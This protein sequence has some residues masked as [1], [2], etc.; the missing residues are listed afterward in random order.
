MNIN[1]L[2]LVLQ[3]GLD[4]KPTRE[5]YIFFIVSEVV[6]TGIVFFGVFKIFNN[7]LKKQKEEKD[8]LKNLKD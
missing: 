1:T 6:I 5:F 7:F 4:E 8:A 2:L 3:A